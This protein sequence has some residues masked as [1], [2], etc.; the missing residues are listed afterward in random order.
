MEKDIPI[1][2]TE[3]F[4][5]E[6]LKVAIFTLTILGITVWNGFRI[7]NFTKKESTFLSLFALMIGLVVGLA[8][9]NQPE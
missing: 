4:N 1:V 6:T 7:S 9:H 3:W 5:I 2:N 8:V